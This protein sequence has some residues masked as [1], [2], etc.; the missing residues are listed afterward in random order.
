V[1]TRFLLWAP[2]DWRPP[3]L[4]SAAWPGPSITPARRPVPRCA[5]RAPGRPRP[6]GGCPNDQFATSTRAQPSRLSRK[7]S[8]CDSF[9]SSNGV[10]RNALVA[11]LS[12]SAGGKCVTPGSRPDLRGAREAPAVLQLCPDLYRAHRADAV[13][14]FDERRAVG[15]AACEAAS[16]AR[17]GTSR[18]SV[19][20]AWAAPWSPRRSPAVLAPAGRGQ[21]VKGATNRPVCHQRPG[22]TGA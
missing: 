13:V 1:T 22:A 10:N 21:A 18:P 6:P 3:A 2:R 17:R 5:R 8:F 11:F 15:L 7:R 4:I 9:A 12:L 19:A 16:L 14:G 20:G